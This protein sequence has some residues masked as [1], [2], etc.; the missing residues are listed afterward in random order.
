MAVSV[1]VCVCVCF[2]SSGCL[3]GGVG[4][5]LTVTLSHFELLVGAVCNGAGPTSLTTRRAD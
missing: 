5:L 2:C 4:S 1:C 3:M